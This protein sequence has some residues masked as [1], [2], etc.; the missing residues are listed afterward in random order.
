[1]LILLHTCVCIQRVGVL[2]RKQNTIIQITW[3]QIIHTSNS[4]AL[5][6]TQTCISLL[7]PL[8]SPCTCPSLLPSSNFNLTSLISLPPSHYHT[9]STIAK[10]SLRVWYNVKHAIKST[11]TN[12]W[13][14]YLDKDK[15]GPQ[16]RSTQVTTPSL[17][18]THLLMSP[19]SDRSMENPISLINCFGRVKP[20]VTT[21]S[22][23]QPPCLS[24]GF[25]L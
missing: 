1:M 18:Y 8:V 14:N 6:P 21:S 3:V 4:G 22:F 23:Y 20:P 11:S 25:L 17:D 9:H 15:R 10:D 7:H 16:L 13:L 2:P 12:A 19:K 24:L 5:I